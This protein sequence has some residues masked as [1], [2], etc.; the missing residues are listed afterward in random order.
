MSLPTFRRSRL[1]LTGLLLLC[2]GVEAQEPARTD[3]GM[4]PRFWQAAGGVAAVNGL[5][6]FHNWHVQRWHWSNVGT[7]SWWAN[8]RG[9][10]TWD[11]DVFGVN[12]AAHPYHGSLY[13]NAARSSGYDFWSSTPFVTAGSL[14]WELFA[15]NVRPSLNDLINTTLGG[16]ALGEA[17]YRMSSLLSKGG[18]SRRMGA[19]VVSPVARTHAFLQRRGSQADSDPVPAP[20]SSSAL[21][22]VGQ[23]RSS[24][25]SP[26][27]VSG[28]NA[29]VGVSVQYGSAFGDGVT[30]PYDAFEFSLQLSPEENVVLSHVAVSGVLSRRTIVRSTGNQLF[31]A[32][33]Q[34]YDYDD[35]PAFKASSQSLSG[36]LLFR[37][38][39]GARTDVDLGLHLEAV[40][41]AAVSSEHQ[42]V[43]RRDYDLGP[44]FGGRFMGSVRRDRRDLLRLDARTVWV[45]SLHGADADHLTA[46][47]RFSAAIPVMR[48]V[49][50]GGDV[51]LTVRRSSYR[52]EPRV[53]KRIPQL[54]AYLLWSPS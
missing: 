34:H 9:G 22:A 2:A 23:R 19:F 46:T 24:G 7:Q 43:R 51:G 50:V 25:A 1:V 5:L 49:S 10:F 30:R 16:I 3:G 40:P 20:E 33:F 36:A 14:G 13:F 42:G 12:Q 53:T 8:V 52:A 44:G 37:R 48:M 39:A 26:S 17:A 28:S 6:W 38:K 27:G 29:F 41:L 18:F 32:L 35:L 45:H 31:L 47:A 54:R 15:E 21:V 11:D 4:E